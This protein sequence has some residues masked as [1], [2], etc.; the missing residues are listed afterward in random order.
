M[1]FDLED[2]QEQLGENGNEID[3]GNHEQEQ[4]K[5]ALKLYH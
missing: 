3:E 1:H 5:Y 2:I 4:G